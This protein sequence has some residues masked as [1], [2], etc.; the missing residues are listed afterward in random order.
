MPLSRRGLLAAGGA[1]GVA[2]ALSACGFSGIGAAERN[3]LSL[4][5]PLFEDAEGKVA[6]EQT[7][8]GP[9]LG[10]HPDLEMSVDYIPWDR[11]NEKLSTAFAGGLVPDVIM[12]GVG[13]TP[14]FAEKG[15]FGELPEDV[16]DDLA[17]HERL[18]DACR[19]DGKLFALPF[20]MEG[21]FLAYRRAPLEER[22]ISEDQ[23]PTSLEELREMG[24]E[25]QGGDL[26]PFDL[27]SNNI[28]QTWIHLMAAYGGSLFSE[29]GTQ[30][31]FDD[32]TGEAAIEYL[33]TL[34]EDGS[35]QFGLRWAQGQPRPI[36][37]ERVAMELLNNSVWPTL[38]EQTPELVNEEN[39]GLFL[40]PGD[41]G[42][43]PVMFLGGTLIS[44]SGT[45][46]KPEVTQEFLHHALTPESLI[47]ASRHGGRAPG[48]TELPDDD[49]V[50]ANRFTS[51][52]LE[53]LDYAGAAEGGS[54]AWMEIRDQV[55]PQVE[56]AVTRA[57]S[58]A[59][60]IAELKRMTEE[61]LQRI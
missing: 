48:V 38:S 31:A 7:I 17:V 6:L 43:D 51:Y 20:Q 1:T 2:A 24:K 4:I 29:D 8:A 37:Q 23:L 49:V 5:T 15:I 58:P 35:T 36:Q 59:E 53:N 10:S 54:P 30:V 32:G 28:R 41:A 34:I 61:A 18:L 14:P 57:Q 52:T 33:I 56:A 12:S 22:G 19:F 21:R 60:T 16:L 50:G 27:F 39:M 26:V 45:T 13:W 11:L 44:M 46:N 40:L 47:A 42:M 3:E 9:F 25:L 55:G